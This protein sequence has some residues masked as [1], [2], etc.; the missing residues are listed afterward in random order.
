MR[1]LFDVARPSTDRG[2][3]TGELELT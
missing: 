1:T 2:E 3:A